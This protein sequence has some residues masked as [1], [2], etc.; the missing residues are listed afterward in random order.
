M[1][2]TILTAVVALGSR[3]KEDDEVATCPSSV[4]V[5]GSELLSFILCSCEACLLVRRTYVEQM[6]SLQIVAT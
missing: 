2:L 5:G 6:L 4:V 3:D 1:K